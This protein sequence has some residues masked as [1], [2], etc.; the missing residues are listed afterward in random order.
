MTENEFKNWSAVTARS[1]ERW[2]VDPI[3]LHNRQ[4]YLIYKGGE[5]GKFIEVHPDGKLF[6]GDYE[7]AA[8]HIGEA[9]FKVNFSKTFESQDAALKRIVEAGGMDF[10][11]DFMDLTLSP[12]MMK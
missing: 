3:A 1:K 6:V 9:F 4:V 2:T 7:G 5:D 11:L 10:L 12:E 8:P